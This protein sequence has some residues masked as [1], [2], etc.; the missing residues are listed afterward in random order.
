M[1]KAYDTLS[2]IVWI[3]LRDA[4][5]LATASLGSRK[6]AKALLIEWLA[7]GKLPWS[8]I[9]WRVLD[10]EGIA[11]LERA[12]G[13]GMIPFRYIPSTC[14]EGEPEFWRADLTIDWEDNM[15]HENSDVGPRALGIKVSR[16][17]LLALLPDEP[18]ERIEELGQ[19]K[20]AERELLE[21][22]A[23]PA[24][25]AVP[26]KTRAQA[27]RAERYIAKHFPNGTDG[28]TT[29]KIHETLVQDKDL[30]TELKQ[31]GSWDVPSQTAINRVLGRRKA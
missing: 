13:D 6:L 11:E 19:T 10:V 5:D 16:E 26:K 15:A 3:W 27:E 20:P 14:R 9:V 24:P 4:S 22:K 7:A 29:A 18:R 1:A 25:T 21:P 2:T 12:Q 28:I 17:H 30:Q 23:R 8:C 31:L